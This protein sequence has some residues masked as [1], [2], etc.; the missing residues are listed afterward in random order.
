MTFG[1]GAAA[2]RSCSPTWGTGQGAFTSSAQHPKEDGVAWRVESAQTDLPRGNATR[3]R[4]A[5]LVAGRARDEVRR[6]A[7]SRAASRSRSPTWG[8]GQT[9]LPRG[10]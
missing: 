2:S 5:E 6:T 7:R 1:D 8:T 10:N 4:A 3:D 9:D